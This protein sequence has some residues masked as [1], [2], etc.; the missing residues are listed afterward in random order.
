VQSREIQADILYNILWKRQRAIL[1]AEF[2]RRR[3]ADIGRRVWEYNALTECLKQVPVYSFVIYLVKDSGIVQ[4]PYRRVL[5]DG[6][7]SHVF[8]YTN[9]YLWELPASA[10]KGPGREGLLPLLPLTKNGARREVIEEMIEELQAAHKQDLLA[11]AYSFAALVLQKKE[12]RQWL[13][14][15]FEMLSD[16]LEDSWAFQELKERAE[17]RAIEKAR[18]EVRQEVRQEV[19]EEVREEVRQEVREE[20][21]QEV[22]EEARR[23]AR[24]EAEREVEQRVEQARR[25]VEQRVEQARREVERELS[26]KM[27]QEVEQLKRELVQQLARQMEREV[28]RMQ[29]EE[30]RKALQQG[31]LVQERETLEQYVQAHFP[32]LLP[33]LQER[34][35]S[36]QN[37]GTLRQLL[38][39]LL[40]ARGEDEA[41][42][43]I[44]TAN[45]Q[46]E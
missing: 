34:A 16:I 43:L 28:A 40:E 21:R 37:L 2:Q 7:I 35:E 17:K 38:F 24:Q 5:P 14:R 46:A 44:L 36:I 4:P 23:E 12:D 18:E 10:F 41:R 20:V 1:H 26:Q 19:R 31:R 22:R 30:A 9:V 27:E 45:D 33:L 11:L 6:S 32:A 25:E 13:K 39:H 3:D 29:E 8:Y 15:R 42:S